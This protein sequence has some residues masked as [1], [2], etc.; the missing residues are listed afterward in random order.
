M[1][2]WPVVEGE[3]DQFIG[4]RLEQHAIRIGVHRRL[5]ANKS[6]EAEGGEDTEDDFQHVRFLL[7]VIIFRIRLT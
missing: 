4:N 5:C 1:A 3:Y 7:G 2:G 6:W